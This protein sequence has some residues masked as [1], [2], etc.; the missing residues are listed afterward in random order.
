M[1][2]LTGIS[3]LKSGSQNMEQAR[4]MWNSSLILFKFVCEDWQLESDQS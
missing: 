4:A 2:S 1:H 3:T